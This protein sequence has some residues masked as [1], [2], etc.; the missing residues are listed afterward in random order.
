M[1]KGPYS[2]EQILVGK[3]SDTF[4]Q[5]STALLLAV[6]AGYCQRALVYESGMIRSQIGKHKRSVMAAVYRPLV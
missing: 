5:V 4:C 2:M 1:L 3:N 6:S